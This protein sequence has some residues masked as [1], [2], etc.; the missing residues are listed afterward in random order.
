MKK[1]LIDRLVDRKLASGGKGKAFCICMARR[2]CLAA[3]QPTGQP[4]KK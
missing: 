2:V 4:A 3:V 1:Q